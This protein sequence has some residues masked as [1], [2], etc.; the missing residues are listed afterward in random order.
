[1]D[2]ADPL[3]SGW[4]LDWADPLMSGWVLNPTR[5]MT[6]PDPSCSNGLKP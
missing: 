2:W 4:V 6:L 3:M 1:M 5:L